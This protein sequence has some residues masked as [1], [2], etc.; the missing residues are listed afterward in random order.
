MVNPIGKPQA[1]AVGRP[2][3]RA[4]IWPTASAANS[5]WT[6]AP[7]T[8]GKELAKQAWLLERSAT[9][10]AAATGTAGEGAG[11]GSGFGRERALNRSKAAFCFSES[12]PF[13]CPPDLE[14]PTSA[15]ASSFREAVLFWYD[16]AEAGADTGVVLRRF[17]RPNSSTSSSSEF[18]SLWFWLALGT[19]CIGKT[20]CTPAGTCI[21]PGTGGTNGLNIADW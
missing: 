21:G 11:V 12:P 13:F 15:L 5:D 19:G 18:H 1:S 20:G 16:K 2:S 3:Q 14:P 4:P 7:K 8:G 6:L 9:D 10:R 17:F